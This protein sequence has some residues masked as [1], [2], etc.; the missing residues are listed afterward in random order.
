MRIRARVGPAIDHERIGL[1]GET[2]GIALVQ[3]R[4]RSGGGHIG[5]ESQ[6]R[7]HRQRFQNRTLH[8][9]PRIWA[10]DLRGDRAIRCREGR[11][12]VG[13][14][15]RHRGEPRWLRDGASA[16]PNGQI[17]HEL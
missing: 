11:R 6:W 9:E 13:L 17:L 8:A 12:A 4:D 7:G 5:G 15:H 16:I 14:L 1:C 10:F 3:Q 2:Q